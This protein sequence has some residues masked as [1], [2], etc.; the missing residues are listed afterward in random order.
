MESRV[1]YRTSVIQSESKSSP[2]NNTIIHISKESTD[3]NNQSKSYSSEATTHTSDDYEL[4]T[5]LIL[6]ARN[7]KSILQS[8]HDRQKLNIDINTNT[9][10][11]FQSRNVERLLQRQEK[12]RKEKKSNKSSSTAS[13]RGSKSTTSQSVSSSTQKLKSSQSKSGKQGTSINES[14]R[15]KVNKFMSKT[16]LLPVSS[17]ST[18]QINSTILDDH[19]E[20]EKETTS[21]E[22]D[23]Y[24][25]S[26][27][28]HEQFLECQLINT[29]FSRLSITTSTTK[30]L[31]YS[32]S[33][34]E[35]LD[36]KHRVPILTTLKK[37][38][39]CPSDIPSELRREVLGSGDVGYGYRL[40]D[41][42]LPQSL[43]RSISRKTKVS[44]SKIKKK[45]RSSSSSGLS[46]KR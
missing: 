36:H 1:R 4:T 14:A 38:L 19:E 12:L 21:V 44:I 33:P 2:S 26:I 6:H 9:N 41:N 31:L 11:Y 20:D 22:E 27:E 34:L 17:S 25:H 42:P 3:E 30:S 40:M 18:I 43:R 24:P 28:S 39:V 8:F 7:E 29:S 23:I 10:G 5:K 37:A 35:T 13:L 32:P 45:K 16:F 46:S 15:I